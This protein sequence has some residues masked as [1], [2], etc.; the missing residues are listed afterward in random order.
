MATS[1]EQGSRGESFEFVG[2]GFA[3]RLFVGDKSDLLIQPVQ[4]FE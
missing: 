2:A 1:G 4:S 3:K